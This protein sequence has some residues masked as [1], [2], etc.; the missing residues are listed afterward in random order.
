LE[1]E[2][3]RVPIMRQTAPYPTALHSLV[4]RATYRPGWTFWLADIDR[5]KDPQGGVA[6][7]GLTLC[8]T[9]KG[10]NTYK[11]SEG[12]TYRVN[13]Y[14]IVPA[15][16]YDERAWLR[17]LFDQ[18]LLVETHEAMEFFKID[19]HRPYAPNHGPGRNPYTVLER[20]TEEDAATMFTGAPTKGTV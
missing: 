19:K 14:F 6:G 10:Y 8:I 1:V 15:A 4:E 3:T 17:W 12:E 11:P 7:G 2:M 18:I 5:D 20:G 9:T 13:H 16:T